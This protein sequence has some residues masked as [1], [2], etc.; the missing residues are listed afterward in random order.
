MSMLLSLWDYLEFLF[1]LKNQNSEIVQNERCN[2]VVY[3]ENN[4]CVLFH[5]YY[6]K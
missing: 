3:Q 4:Y 1:V 5:D 6:L 2:S